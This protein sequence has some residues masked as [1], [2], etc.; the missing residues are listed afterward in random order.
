VAARLSAKPSTA[1]HVNNLAVNIFILEFLVISRQ[2]LDAASR[3]LPKQSVGD[4]APARTSP[5][6]KPNKQI[7]LIVSEAVNHAKSRDY[8]Q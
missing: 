3:G 2:S 1:V 8:S 6:R 4:K 7:G 5:A